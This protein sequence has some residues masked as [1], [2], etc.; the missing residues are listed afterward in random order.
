MDAQASTRFIESVQP[1][2]NYITAL[3]N[4]RQLTTRILCSDFDVT[5]DVWTN[6]DTFRNV[7]NEQLL[8]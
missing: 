7:T 6:L 5:D 3:R 2:N 4:E 8:M 1:L